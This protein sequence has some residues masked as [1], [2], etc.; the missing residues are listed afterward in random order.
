MKV[1]GGNAVL[2]IYTGVRPVAAV[3]VI[4]FIPVTL[5][6][7]LDSILITY[8]MDTCNSCSYTNLFLK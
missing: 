5:L 6:G 7:H 1:D 8:T 4:R 3:I 2:S